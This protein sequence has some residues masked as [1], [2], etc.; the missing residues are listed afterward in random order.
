MAATGSLQRILSVA[1]KEAV[2]IR[3]DPAAFFFALALP[4]IQ[5]FM[6]GYA[7]DTN[8]RHIRTVVLD[9]CCTQ[10]TKDLLKSFENSEDFTIID[11]VR[12]EADLQQAIVAGRAKVGIHIPEDYS[13]RLDMKQ[14]AQ[15]LI[16]VDG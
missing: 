12:T 9:E 15:V 14:T 6:L 3:R 7:I 10:E 16:L 4:M 1:R 8:V 5:M 11:Y 2:H 13:R